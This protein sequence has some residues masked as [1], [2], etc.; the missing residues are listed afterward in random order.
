MLIKP[1]DGTSPA[2]LKPQ[3]RFSSPGRP[4]L[5]LYEGDL[6]FDKNT[7]QWFYPGVDN[8]GPGQETSPRKSQPSPGDDRK[9]RADKGGESVVKLR[10][11]SGAGG[12]PPGKPKQV[13]RLEPPKQTN[14]LIPIGIALGALFTC[15]IGVAAGL[16]KPSPDNGFKNQPNNSNSLYQTY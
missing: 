3:E 9:V 6:Q 14:P 1:V 13:I 4:Q 2:P 8:A 16:T 11:E 10:D 7:Q 5:S 12:T 15:V